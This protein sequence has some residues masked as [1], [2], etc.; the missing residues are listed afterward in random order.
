MS[1]VREVLDQVLRGHE[2]YPAFVVDRHWGMVAGNQAVSVLTE[3][4]A[5]ELLE[6]PANVLRLALHPDGIAPRIVNLPELRA[7]LLGSLG[8]QAVS[9]GDP[10]LAAL[11][12]ELSELPGG[13]RASKQA[14][15]EIAVPLRIRW[16]DVE[17]SFI[18]TIT[19]FSRATDITVA[20]L[21][22]ESFFP[23]DEA[24]AEALRG[25]AAAPTRV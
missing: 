13:P 4:A 8:R 16:G 22:I 21:A 18:S 24:T 1:T 2:P 15:A 20:E 9:T 7:R 12:E 11:F 17:L 3:G 10:A 14:A 25:V 6:P 23:A 5:P 19:T